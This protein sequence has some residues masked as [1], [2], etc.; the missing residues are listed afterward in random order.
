MGGRL[1]AVN[2]KR[3]SGARLII[4][5]G[6]V[7]VKCM[8][9]SKRITVPPVASKHYISSQKSRRGRAPVGLLPRGKALSRCH[10]ARKNRAFRTV[11]SGWPRGKWVGRRSSPARTSCSLAPAGGRPPSEAPGSLAAGPV[12]SEPVRLPEIVGRTPRGPRNLKMVSA[13]GRGAET[14]TRRRLEP[15]LADPASPRS[16]P[17]SAEPP[18]GPWSAPARSTP[19]GPAAGPGVLSRL[20]ARRFRPRPRS[21]PAPTARVPPD[22][23]VTLGRV[24][25]EQ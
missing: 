5:N 6:E 9:L 17:E 20:C 11:Q 10:S 1:N 14:G 8:H 3:S 23:A 12:A 2:G 24:R 7:T 21:L 4:I 25:R 19:A 15:A 16:S 22:G 18:L 13:R